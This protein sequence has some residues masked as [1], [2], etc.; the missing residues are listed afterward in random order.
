MRVKEGEHGGDLGWL[1]GWVGAWVDRWTCVGH[2]CMCLHVSAV[3]R[4]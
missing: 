3:S 2:V 4:P 1:A